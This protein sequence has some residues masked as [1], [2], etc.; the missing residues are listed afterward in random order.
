MHAAVICY[1][2]FIVVIEAVQALAG[3]D[4]HK[5]VLKCLLWWTSYSETASNELSRTGMITNLTNLLSIYT[6]LGVSDKVCCA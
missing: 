2:F 1:L 3:H 5:I 6:N 4:I